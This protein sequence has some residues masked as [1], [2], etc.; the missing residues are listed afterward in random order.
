M[1]KII[2]VKFILFLGYLTSYGQV[3]PT[4]GTTSN[5]T[6]LAGTQITSNGNTVI[7]DNIGIWPGSILTGFPPGVI[8]GARHIN[9]TT[10]QTAQ[11]DLTS[12]Y[13]QLVA[14]TPTVTLSGQDLGG[15]TLLPGVY[16]FNGNANLDA[17]LG[18]LTLDGGGNANSVFIFQISGNLVTSSSAV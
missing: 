4:L 3:K 10:A 14:Q 12:A 7:Y 11:T 5:F 16:R 13:N 18:A 2:L 15:K 8:N 9:N 17:T 6:V 1:K